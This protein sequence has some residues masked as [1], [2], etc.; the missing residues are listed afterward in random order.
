MQSH[1]LASER[2]LIGL[3]FQRTLQDSS[4]L[5]L[6]FSEPAPLP[7]AIQNR[8]GLLLRLVGTEI[9]ADLQNIYDTSDFATLVTS[10]Q[11]EQRGRIAEIQLDA[12]GEYSYVLNQAE[13]Q[14]MI[15]LA[16]T[17][18]K[19]TET[20]AGPRFRYT[21]EK[22]SLNY[23]DIPVRQLLGQLADFLGLNLI[24]SDSVTGNIT[25]LLN[26]VPSDQALDIILT[27]KG[28][29]S[30]Q[31]GNVLLVAPAAQL[32]ALE[33]EQQRATQS[34]E[35]SVPLEDAFIRISYTRAA[36]IHRFI[37]GD[38][39]SS[40][41]A[42]VLSGLSST[43][44]VSPATLATTRRFMSSR[45]HL[46][47]D[48]RTNTLYV[49]DTPEQVARI[50]D[51]VQTLDIPVQQV[52]IE[53]RIV[54]ARSGVSNELGVSWGA[55]RATGSARAG[56]LTTERTR[57]LGAMD[58][59]QSLNSNRGGTIDFNPSSGVNFGFVSNN[60]ILD[61][62]LAALETENRSEIISQPRVITSDRVKAVIRS[63]EEIPYE[64]VNADG[65]RATAFR[66]AELRLE[67]TPNIVSNGRIF[68]ELQ[69][70]NDSKGEETL[71]A[72]PTINTNAVETQ[73]LVNNGETLVI[74]GIFTSQQLNAV[75]KTP[76]F[77]DLPLVG[78]LFRRSF[79]S[80]EKVEL[81]VFITPR[82][83]NDT[84]L[85]RN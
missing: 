60:L 31:Q 36:D 13:N 23:Q 72:G 3:D 55:S 50:R 20:A 1:A 9:R 47:V 71:R 63:G 58:N 33:E 70:N 61:L 37:M 62:E 35:V 84:T 7:E 85:A 68:L 41:S 29:A 76:F 49:R 8:Q 40:P 80:N 32:V 43:S 30:R 16:P 56:N 27:T 64:T 69:V 38:Q 18:V 75:A 4:R 52:M 66:Q 67:V 83:I 25:L 12:R 21:G 5:V 57:S 34:A 6:Q 77:G 73:V 14:L 59:E 44:E 2:V 82:L 26:D 48:E 51:I 42:T 74:G 39:Q 11:L 28:L 22:I 17:P 53:A 54:V 24:A 19:T 81:L 10:I 65:E 78:W 46:L 15:E 45:G 79:S